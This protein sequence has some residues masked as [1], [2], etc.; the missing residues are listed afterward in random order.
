M[1][2]Q[3]NSSKHLRNKEHQSYSISSFYRANTTLMKII[4]KILE[5]RK[6]MGEFFMNINSKNPNTHTYIHI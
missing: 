3:S 2:L 5:E 1:A 6:I 4:T